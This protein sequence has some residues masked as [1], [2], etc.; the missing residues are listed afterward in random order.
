MKL[1]GSPASPYARK[2]RVL[3]REKHIPCEFVVED[4]WPADSRIPERNP[5]GKVPVLEIAPGSYLF[6]SP[7]VV[8]YLDNLDG[9]SIDPRDAAGYW[10]SQWWQALGNGI[11][12][13][14]IAR[15]LETR[16]PE[17]KQMPEKIAREE[18]RVRRAVDLGEKTTKGGGFLVGERF[19]LADLVLG[20]ALQYTDFRYAHDWR[21]RA[22]RL[23][24]WHAGITRR[25]SFEETLPPGFV[26]P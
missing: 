4:P 7:L 17:D 14:V 1:Y 3:I 6:E 16:R 10:Q 21:S 13:A 5:L 2:A 12:D 8:H 22:P 24:R 19:T 20:V 26:K 15:L 18:A 9:E 11:I 25:P 23:A